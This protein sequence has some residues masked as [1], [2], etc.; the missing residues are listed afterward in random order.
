MRVHGCSSEKEEKSHH[1]T[2]SET[3]TSSGDQCNM[4]TSITLKNSRLCVASA[5]NPVFVD[6]FR[7]IEGRKFNYDTKENT[8]PACKESLLAV[9][10]VAG[11]LPWML[12]S[13]IQ[14]ILTEEG[15]K[16]PEAKPVDMGLVNGHTFLTEPFEHQRV[17]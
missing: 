13:E 9:C 11:L 8:F 5:Y 2:K 10:D 16:P 3:A 7:Q 4:K 15:V 12:A 14:A 1:Q 6:R 17:N